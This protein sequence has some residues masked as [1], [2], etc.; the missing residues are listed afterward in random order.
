MTMDGGDSFVHEPDN[1]VQFLLLLL[2]VLQAP[3]NATKIPTY[4]GARNWATDMI[5][6]DLKSMAARMHKA[7]RALQERD[8]ANSNER[9]ERDTAPTPEP[10]RRTNST[11]PTKPDTEAPVDP[12]PEKRERVV[13]QPNGKPMKLD[14]SSMPAALS[15][16]NGV[17]NRGYTDAAGQ[18][19]TKGPVFS[20]SAPPTV[21]ALP[22]SI[23]CPTCNSKV[24]IPDGIAMMNR[25]RTV[26]TTPAG[27]DGPPPMAPLGPNYAAH[28]SLPRA[29]ELSLLETQVMEVARVCKAVASGDLTQRI[30]I[31]VQGATMV[32]LKD[33]INTMVDKLGVFAEE[34]SR[35]A[36]E[37]GTE[38]KLGGQALVLDVEG[39]WRDLTAIVN[40][41]AAN[42]TSQVRSIATV[43]KAVALGDLSKQ[44]EVEASGEILDLKNTVNGMVIRLRALAAEVTR[45]T[46]EVGSQGKL[47]G[48]ADVPDVEGVWYELVRNVNRMC[49]SLTDQVRSIAVVTTAV[50]GGDLTQKISIQVEGEMA[51]L[52]ATVNSMVDQLSAFASEVTRVALEVGTQGILGGQ[53]TVEGVQGTWADLTRNVNKMASNLTDQ[54]RSISEVTKAVANGDLGKMVDVNVQGEMLDLKMTVNQMVSQLSTLA[55]EVTRV[56]LEVGTEGILGGQA[57]VPGVQG[58]WAV[59]TDNVNLMAMNLT[60]QVRSIA[61]VTKAVAGGDLSKKITVD[62]KGEILELKDTVNGMTDSL[63][64]FADEVTRV[65]KEVGTDGKLGGQARVTNVGGTWKALTDNVN[66]MAA[67]LTLQ[68]RT[69]AEATAAVSVGDLTR[70]IQ[71]VSVSGE[72]LALVNTINTMIDQLSIFA[73]EVKKVAREVGTDGK[74]G[75]QAEVGNVQGIWQEITLAVNTMA[76]NL[77]TQVRGFAQ[78]SQ[79]AMDGDFTRFI[80][81]E[82][83][84]EMDSLKT[85]IN[86]MVF[87]LRDSIQKNTAAREAA[88]LA[89]R[90]KS[91]FLANMSHEIRTPMN[92]IIGMTELTLDSDLNRSQRESLLLVHSLARSLLLIIDDIL[93][94]SKIEAGRMTMEAVSYSL[95]QTV[96]GILKTLVV[97]A[98]QNNLDLTYDVEA[99]IPDQLIGDALRLRQVITNLVGNAI[100]F[101]PSQVSRKGNVAL[102]TR[103]LAMDGE[104]VTIEFCVLDTGIGIA[105]DKLSLIFDTFAQ[106]DGSTTREYGGTGLGL[107]ISKR[108]VSLMQGDMWVESEVSKGSKFYFTI[109]TQISH[110]TLEATLTKMQPFAKRTILYMNTLGDRSNV[111]EKIRLLGLKP[112]VATTV[113]QVANKDK[114]PHVDT[115]ITDSLAITEGVREY[116]HLRYI[117]I[118]LLGPEQPKLNL[119]WCLDNSISSQV[120]SPVSVQDL[121]SALIT[122]LESNTQNPVFTPNDISFDILLA[123]DNMVNQK[124]AVKILEK[125][126][127]MVE[128]ADNGAIA[129]DAFK[130]RIA[131]SKPF[132]IILMDVSMPFMGGMEATELIRQFE[133]QEGLMPTPIIALTAHAM[134]GDRERC[135][136]AGMDDHIT[137]PLR[138]GDLLNAISKL[139]SERA[140]QKAMYR[141][142]NPAAYL[143][144]SALRS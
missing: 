84:G 116:E 123:E 4:Q 62:V 77:T 97:R 94:I 52:K 46:L 28:A 81:V 61:E 114:C 142:R 135:L 53:A 16:L 44:I 125:Y 22:E 71:G 74:L 50:A 27:R 143:D 118:V 49:S 59:L 65:A 90:S 141:R 40:K 100:K 112:H 83:S 144:P 29:Q 113:A 126:G 75:V 66:V 82:A 129:V 15:E 91:E 13:E 9:T 124:L 26:D 87:N 136:R 36:L 57:S 96:F 138:R 93:D 8:S 70:K 98:S 119:K 117:P 38:G 10:R 132:D 3:Q 109:T 130:R 37:V 21:Q 18:S 47:G 54:V 39:T 88:E 72:M 5:L 19:F 30:D 58:M 101:T 51:T 33:I 108:L 60:N 20:H 104:H 78:I 35:V 89:N 17:F 63:S 133:M 111:A 120:T 139:A 69:I 110:S 1:F 45:V 24:K 42:L 95:R 64:L 115:I 99:D 31:P 67:N 121:A 2:P 14:I 86:S 73:R 131:E 107:S 137:K 102:S 85:Q 103:L 12:P 122:A 43:T 134:I 7:E 55:N 32:Q 23:N 106:A 79:A 25:F 92:G 140:A 76:G 41:L 105:Q 127:N 68:V 34:V 128:I 56:S 48:Q 6:K 80:T 11:P